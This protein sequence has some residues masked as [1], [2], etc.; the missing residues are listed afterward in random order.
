MRVIAGTCKGRQLRSP[1][2]EGLRPTS[3]RL[4][5]TLFNVL[6]PRIEGARL[7]DLF[8]G[9]GAIGIEA[10]SRG[11]SHV[12]FVERDPRAVALIED[13]LR[14]CGMAKGYAIIRGDAGRFL[15]TVPAGQ[16]FDLIVLD[17]PYAAEA[18]T[19]V[20]L[21]AAAG[22]LAGDGLLVLERGTRHTPPVV[23]GLE[24][25]RDLRSGDS[26]LS[27]YERR[28]AAAEDAER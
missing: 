20:A 19:R 4:R 22:H 2:W 16:P 24:R 12:T 8:A 9:T 18:D 5:E 21:A 7:L 1:G 28:A 17:P 15:R 26:T 14:H 10:L 25:V 11:A 27:F 6:A 13:N 23:A 3:D